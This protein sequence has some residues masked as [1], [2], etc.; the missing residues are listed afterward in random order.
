MIQSSYISKL[1]GLIIHKTLVEAIYV[2]DKRWNWKVGGYQS[3]VF[4]SYPSLSLYIG[5]QKTILCWYP[6]PL[7]YAGYQKK[8]I[9]P[10]P[11][12]I[13]MPGYHKKIVL[14]YP[15]NLLQPGYES[16][17][18]VWYPAEKAF[19]VIIRSWLYIIQIKWRFMYNDYWEIIHKAFK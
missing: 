4:R 6:V 8:N 18:I 9:F 15:G 3:R 17:K 11:D 19:A 14:P 2:Q 1:E 5:Y 7:V 13:P 16:E 10:Y 12:A